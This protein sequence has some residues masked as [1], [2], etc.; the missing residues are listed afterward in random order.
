MVKG[1][2]E[3]QLANWRGKCRRKIGSQSTRG[4]E[5]NLA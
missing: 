4:T 3:G 1:A 5:S 2:N